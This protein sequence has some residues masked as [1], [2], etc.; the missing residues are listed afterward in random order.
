MAAI[1]FD[2]KPRDFRGPRR[3]AETTYSFY[4]RSSL[5]E[6]A[7]LRRMLQSWI[8]RLPQEHGQRTVA[9]MRHEGFGSPSEE[10]QFNAAFLELFVHEFLKGTGS[11]AAVEPEIRGLTP[12]FGVMEAA[13]DGVEFSYV[14]EATDINIERNSDLE[15]AWNERAAFDI[16]NEMESPDFFLR[17]ETEGR[18][19][20][21]PRKQDLKRPF[22]DLLRDTDYDELL[23]D[24]N[25]DEINWNE[26]PSVS[27]QHDGWTLAGQLIPVAPEHRPA[28]GRF[29]GL[30]P[31]RSGSFDDIGR[32][33]DRLYEKA[34]RYK[35]VENL[36]IA[37]RTGAW[38]IRMLEVLFGTRFV[39]LS[40]PKDPTLIGTVGEAQHGQRQDGFWFNS[41]G[42][43]NAHVIGVVAFQNLHPHCIG[44]TTAVYFSNPYVDKPQPAWAD[45]I[46][47]AEYSDGEITIVAGA[48]PCVFIEDYEVIGNPFE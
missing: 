24:T 26:M 35:D 23:G 30:G 20:S 3:Q 22:Q 19:G 31:W 13:D 16:L 46:T 5:E 1:L 6:Y 7:R 48:T 10:R 21:M 36:V 34:R 15:V 27:F 33:R 4:D 11:Y 32:P 41:K 28:D 8:D 42:P 29:V 18:L 17:V 2:D 12:D 25:Y 38:G 14:V 47:H 39:T 40:V 37:I 45:A 9:R 44:N 43:Q